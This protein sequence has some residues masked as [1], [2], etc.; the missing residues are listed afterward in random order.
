MSQCKT[1]IHLE[2][3]T[4]KL[5]PSK[6]E[7]NNFQEDRD[8]KEP[9]CRDDLE[10]ECRTTDESFGKLKCLGSKEI[11]VSP[12]DQDQDTTPD[13]PKIGSIEFPEDMELN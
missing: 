8:D 11:N 13:V 4:N 5:R 3:F 6:I 10:S 7:E 9:E 2:N 1:T 12:E